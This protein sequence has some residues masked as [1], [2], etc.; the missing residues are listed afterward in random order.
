MEREDIEP[1][2]LETT[3]MLPCRVGEMPSLA[4]F[5]LLSLLLGSTDQQVT[6]AANRAWAKE[7]NIKATCRDRVLNKTVNLNQFSW[8]KFFMFQIKY[9]GFWSPLI[10]SA[11]VANTKI[12]LRPD[13]YQWWCWSTS[14]YTALENS[15]ALRWRSVLG[16]TFCFPLLSLYNVWL[17]CHSILRP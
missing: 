8:G 4:A 9:H 6:L 1:W 14:A 3:K 17:V 15:S 5:C 2:I 16:L 10:W 12:K 7:N 13:I 11:M